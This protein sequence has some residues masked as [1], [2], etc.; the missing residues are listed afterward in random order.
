MAKPNLERLGLPEFRKFTTLPI[1]LAWAYYPTNLTV[2]KS[3]WA[4][5]IR[6]AATSGLLLHRG[7]P[8]V[9]QRKLVWK[10]E[11]PLEYVHRDKAP[12]L[13]NGDLG[14]L[15]AELLAEA[16]R[17]HDAGIHQVSMDI[18]AKFGKVD[19]ERFIAVKRRGVK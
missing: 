14:T 10:A 19:Y 4:A 17:R 16:N 8:C 15:T 7:S 9:T 5:L 11:L 2:G 6:T 18:K 1:V 13:L 3:D 12:A